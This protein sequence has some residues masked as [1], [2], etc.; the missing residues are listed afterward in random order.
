MIKVSVEPKKGF[1]HGHILIQGLG[2]SSDKKTKIITLN[3][4]LIVH[5]ATDESTPPTKENVIVTTPTIIA[6]IINELIKLTSPKFLMITCLIIFYS[7][8][9]R[10]R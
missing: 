7:T 5:Y 9:S 4:S 6:G 10:E 1:D 8:G 2:N 3:E